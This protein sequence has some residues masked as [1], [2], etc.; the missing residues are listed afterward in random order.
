VYFDVSPLWWPPLYAPGWYA[1]YYPYP[2]PYPYPYPYYGGWYDAYP[3]PSI[4]EE[5]RVYVEKPQPPP[6][7]TEG[8]WYY[9]T[10]SRAYYPS[11]QTCPEAWV[12][13]PPR[14]E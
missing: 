3:P 11:V 9:C 13:V 14:P 10:S 8:Y 12:K 1:P 6:P 2:R 4:V 7:P 5:P